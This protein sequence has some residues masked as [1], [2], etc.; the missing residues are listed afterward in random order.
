MLRVTPLA[1]VSA[2]YPRKSRKA[3]QRCGSFF[4]V[5]M[6]PVRPNDILCDAKRIAS[7]QERGRGNPRAI[8]IAIWRAMRLR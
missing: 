7:A 2:D 4:A 3:W 6:R 1:S 5:P 8:H